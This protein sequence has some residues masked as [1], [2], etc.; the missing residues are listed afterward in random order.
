M[1]SILKLGVFLNCMLQSQWRLVFL[2][3][4]CDAFAKLVSHRA[5][6]VITQQAST[7]ANVNYINLGLELYLNFLIAAAGTNFNVEIEM[8]QNNMIIIMVLSFK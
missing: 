8:G 5:D 1:F 2:L 3:W 7:P 6:L 4:I